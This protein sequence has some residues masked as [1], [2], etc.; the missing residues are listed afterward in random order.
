[1][2]LKK[3]GAFATMDADSDAAKDFVALEDWLNDGIP[4][5]SRVALECLVDWYGDNAPA[6][7]DWVCAGKPMRPA[8]LACPL[9]L[10][11]PANDRIVP[12]GSARGLHAAAGR[13]TMVAP[14]LGHIGM[15]VGGKAEALLWRPLAD[16]LKSTLPLATEIGMGAKPTKRLSAKPARRYGGARSKPR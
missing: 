7:G 14:P 3:F 11:V 10:A 16:W 9:W 5:A 6:K 12:P 1:L 2:S 8:E 4:L 15:M 13:G